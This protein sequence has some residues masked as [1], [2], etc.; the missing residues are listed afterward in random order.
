MAVVFAILAGCL[1]GLVAVTVRRALD[2]GGDPEVGAVVVA[3]AGLLTAHVLS[4]PELTGGVAWGDLLPFLLVGLFVPGAS[5]VVFILAVRDAGAARVS[6]LIG[7]A[8]ILS[9]VI[10]LAFLDEPFEPLLL[11]ATALVVAG[12]AV[13]A[14]ERDRPAHFRLLGVILALVC[15][16]LFAIRDNL[17][18]WATQDFAAPPVAAAAASL[19]GAT[20]TVLLYL[21]VARRRRLRAHLRPA[22]RSFLPPGLVLGLAYTCLVLGFDRG[23]VGIVAP[24]SATQSLWGVVFSVTLLGRSEAVG[25]RLVVAA[26]LVVAGSA[27]VGAVR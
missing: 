18:R 11:V 16:V 13:L 25:R 12:G 4:I 23:R 5:Q 27:I 22:I 17:V 19:L 6:V 3:G 10:A 26:V 14:F 1:F 21:A 9:V 15:A 7:V 24:L 2:R 20:V 8:P